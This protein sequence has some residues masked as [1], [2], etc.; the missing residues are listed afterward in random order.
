MVEIRTDA[1]EFEDFQSLHSKGEKGYPVKKK[2]FI[3]QHFQ[4]P[5]GESIF[6]SCWEDEKLIGQC[7]KCH[8]RIKESDTHKE[9]L[10]EEGATCLTCHSEAKL[11]KG[12]VLKQLCYYCHADKKGLEKTPEAQFM[13]KTHTPGNKADCRDCHH[14]IEHK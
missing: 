3:W 1:I 2:Y 5:A 7:L 6:I 4:N 10:K 14:I 13:H 11:G 9:Y 12:E 8:K